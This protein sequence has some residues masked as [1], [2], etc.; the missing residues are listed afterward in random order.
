MTWRILNG[1]AAIALYVIAVN[2]AAYEATTPVAD[3]HHTLMRKIYAVGAF[4]LLGLLLERSQWPRLRG[5]LA[6]GLTIGAYSWAIELGQIRLD[7]VHETF[8][9]HGFDVLSGV[10]GGALGALASRAAGRRAI[11]RYEVAA[12]VVL[13]V[14]LGLLFPGTYGALAR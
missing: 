7:H 4:A 13:L 14:V 2:N 1:I 8:A 9:Q 3:P 11:G 10:A 6:A 5:T 12:V